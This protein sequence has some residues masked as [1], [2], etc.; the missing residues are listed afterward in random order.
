MKNGRPRYRN[1]SP[2]ATMTLG[3]VDEDG[4]ERTARD[5]LTVARAKFAGCSVFEISE[6]AR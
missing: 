3:E 5:L 2:S 6:F 1:L 4:D